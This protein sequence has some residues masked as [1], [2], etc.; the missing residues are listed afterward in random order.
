MGGGY[1]MPLNM[2]DVKRV[3]QKCE[4]F[5]LF[6]YCLTETQSCL[7]SHHTIFLLLST[8]LTLFL[9]HSLALIN[10]I[11]Y[12]IMSCFSFL[13][14]S[15]AIFSF[16]FYFLLLYFFFLLSFPLSIFLYPI[17]SVTLPIF[18]LVFLFPLCFS[19]FLALAEI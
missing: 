9:S 19:L 18:S 17:L 6:V 16:T 11:L 10:F 8:F 5:C 2:I 12:N 3:L 7:H 13:L 15:F 1:I 4:M 14:F